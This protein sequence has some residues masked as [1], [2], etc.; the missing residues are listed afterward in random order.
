[1]LPIIK[2]IP[3]EGFYDYAAKYQRSDTQYLFA[4][5]L[6]AEKIKEAYNITQAAYQAIGIQDFGR[7]DLMLDAKG[8]FQLLEANT[9]P[10][11][12]LIH[13]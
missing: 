5:G 11:L 8:Q 4:H 3:K 1:M 6:S 7:I 13:I 12:S 9:L 2:L 10:G